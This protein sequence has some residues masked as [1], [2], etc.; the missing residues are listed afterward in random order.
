MPLHLDEFH[1]QN[2]DEQGFFVSKILFLNQLM[3]HYIKMM[4]QQYSNIQL[5]KQNQIKN[6]I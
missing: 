3:E 2:K 5:V 4:E 1:L 6:Y